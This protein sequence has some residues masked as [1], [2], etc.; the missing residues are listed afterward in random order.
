MQTTEKIVDV[1]DACTAV[2]KVYQFKSYLGAARRHA[3][4]NQVSS[5]QRLV[6]AQMLTTSFIDLN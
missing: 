6:R 5:I 4:V 2:R 3:P 1:L